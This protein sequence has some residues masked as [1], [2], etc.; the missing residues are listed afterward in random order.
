MLGPTAGARGRQPFVDVN[1]RQGVS[2]NDACS[3]EDSECGTVEF[4]KEEV[5]ALLSEKFKGK[6]FDTKVG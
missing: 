1:N 3:T 4:T 6:K 5:D 2:A